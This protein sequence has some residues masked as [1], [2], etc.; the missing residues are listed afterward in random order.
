MDKP[1]VFNFNDGTND[2]DLPHVFSVSDPSPSMK[3]TVIEG[4]RGSGSIVIPGGQKSVE[5]TL[6]GNMIADDYEALTDLISDM[7]S[8]ITT[9]PATLTLMQWTGSA[10]EN[11]WSYAVRRLKEI[12]FPE[13]LRLD[14]QEYEVSFFIISY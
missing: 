11:N 13:S 2:Y 7:K 6:R 4:N 9:N 14:V 10:W 12:N 5:I 8:K 3:S 1:V